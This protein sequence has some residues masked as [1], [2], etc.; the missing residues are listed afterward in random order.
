MRRTIPKDKAELVLKERNRIAAYLFD[1][2]EKFFEAT[3]KRREVEL[4]AVHAMDQGKL[5]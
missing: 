1:E 3:F 2:S 5:A 4:E